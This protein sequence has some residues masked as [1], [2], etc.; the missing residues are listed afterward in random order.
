MLREFVAEGRGQVSGF[1]TAAA[2]SFVSAVGSASVDFDEAQ[3][4]AISRLATPVSGGH[5]LWGA[6]GRGKTMIANLF[7]EAAPTARKKR[8]HFHDFF[9]GLQREIVAARRPIDEVIGEIL[10]DAE[11]IMFDEFHVHDV[12]DAVY[13]SKTLDALLARNTLLFATSNYAPTELMPD[14]LFHDRFLPT[15]Q[16]I[17]SGL[18]VVRLADGVDYRGEQAAQ[19]GDA[20]TG[21]AAGVWIDLLASGSCGGEAVAPENT[22]DLTINGLPVR[23]VSAA[24]GKEATFSFAELCE[25]PLG[26]REYVSIAETYERIRLL[27]VPDL[28]VAP[29]NSLMRLCDLVDVLY[30]RDRRFEV[31]AFGRPERMREAESVPHD[32]SRALSRLSVIARH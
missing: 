13:L 10:G 12:A 30:H 17:E 31:Q 14:P 32:M 9:F 19:T 18:Q 7:Y 1:A 15:I 21:F 26:T 16:Q 22:V 8:F 25:R 20:R 5:Y 2:R 23:A 11:L 4:E 24:D 29:L 27:G 28:A 3:R 6:V